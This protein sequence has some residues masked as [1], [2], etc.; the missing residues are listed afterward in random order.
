MSRTGGKSASKS[1]V[2]ELLEERRVVLSGGYAG[3]EYGSIAELVLREGRDYETVLRDSEH[4]HEPDAPR[5]C[6]RNAAMLSAMHSELSYVEGYASFGLGFAVMHA[7][8]VDGEGRVVD[9]TWAT[10]EMERLGDGVP[11]YRGIELPGRLVYRAVRVTG[12]YGVFDDYR[13]GFPALGI[14][15]FSA[16]ALLEFYEGLRRQ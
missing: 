6:F 5:E 9:T 10:P 2:S 3:L 7:W 1:E 16:E 11:E 4:G 15:P 13:N 12:V 14:S 8:C